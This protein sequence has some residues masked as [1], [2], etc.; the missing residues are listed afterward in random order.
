MDEHIFSE[1]YADTVL[2]EKLVPPT[3]R[4]NHQKGCSTVALRMKEMNAFALGVI[5]RD[6]K[7]IKYLEEFELINEVD[8]SLKLWKHKGRPQYFIQICPALEKWMI[9]VCNQGGID[10][11]E[12]ELSNDFKELSRTT[13]SI[14]SSK[15]KRINNLCA[16]IAERDDI[17]AIRRL[18]A[19]IKYLKAKNYDADI[20]ELKNA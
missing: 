10:M 12:F 20:N 18:K 14:A 17:E 4:Y 1:C 5:D 9:D 16:A 15:D 11:T 6:K 13:K 19:W 3:S 7:E 8:N 2:I